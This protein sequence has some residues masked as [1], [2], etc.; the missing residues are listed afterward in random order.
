MNLDWG[1]RTGKHIGW[2]SIKLGDARERAEWR[3]WIDV[4]QWS[5]RGRL[6]FIVYSSVSFISHQNLRIRIFYIYSGWIIFASSDLC[7]V[8]NAFLLLVMRLN[9]YYWIKV[10]VWIAD[11]TS[12]PQGLKSGLH[13]YPGTWILDIWWDLR[14]F[15]GMLD[16][17]LFLPSTQSEVGNF[18]EA[19]VTV[20]SVANAHQKISISQILKFEMKWSLIPW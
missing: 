19:Y 4:T 2:L 17:L 15:F 9:C 3:K 14:G 5:R 10:S 1:S 8:V 20:F 16:P 6:C 18:C 7:Y 12:W 13:E 11:F